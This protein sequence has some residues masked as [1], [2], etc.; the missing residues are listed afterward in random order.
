MLIYLSSIINQFISHLSIIDLLIY[1]PTYLPI[2]RWLTPLPSL[3]TLSLL[4][5]TLS[6]SSPHSLHLTFREIC[7]MLN[8]Y[9]Q[10]YLQPLSLVYLTLKLKLVP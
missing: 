10:C 6:F 8:S 5:F 3:M 4:L 1:L 9:I 7:I 2:Y